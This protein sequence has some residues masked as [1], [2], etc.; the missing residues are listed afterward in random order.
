MMTTF[1]TITNKQL[2]VALVL[3]S[4]LSASLVGTINFVN[5]YFLLPEVYVS[6]TDEK[7]VKVLNFE[8]GHAFTCSDVDVLLRKY[9]KVVSEETANE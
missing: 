6:K 4:V 7:C 8:N 2:C 3:M 1:Y 5:Q 9:R